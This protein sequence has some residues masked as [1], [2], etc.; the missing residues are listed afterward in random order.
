MCWVTYERFKGGNIWRGGAGMPGSRR[1]KT[2]HLGIVID[3]DD[4]LQCGGNRKK[5]KG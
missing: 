5:K 3:S 1:I 2:S 4:T